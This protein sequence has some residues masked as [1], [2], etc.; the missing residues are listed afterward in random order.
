MFIAWTTV[1]ERA[2]AD[3]L[4]TGAVARG[5]AACVQI[6]GPVVSHYRWQGQLEQAQELRLMFK[7]PASRLS[8]LEAYVLSEHPYDTPEWL[9]VP[10]ERV[11]E[12]YLSWANASSTT[13]PL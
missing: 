6:D 12:K 3:R 8:Q 11:G 13:P 10:V 4:A 2:D 9:A 7:C 5:L 1:A